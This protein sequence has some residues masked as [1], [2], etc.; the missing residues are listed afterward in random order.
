[1]GDAHPTTELGKVSRIWEGGD[2]NRQDTICVTCYIFYTFSLLA[3]RYS[4]CIIFI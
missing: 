2:V 4:F 3:N 1:M